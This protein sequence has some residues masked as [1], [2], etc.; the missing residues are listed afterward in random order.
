MTDSKEVT[1]HEASQWRNSGFRVE[2]RYFV[3]PEKA[4]VNAPTVQR[5]APGIDTHLVRQKGTG[6]VLRL[7][8]TGRKRTLSKS[9]KV[10]RLICVEIMGEVGPT[11]HR[12]E[13]ERLMYEHPNNPSLS[14]VTM[15]MK[16]G[17]LIKVGTLEKDTQPTI[18]NDQ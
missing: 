15:A 5:E 10:C 1:Q 18:G 14:A 11:I 6:A 17:R 16:V 9:E 13:L 3:Y 7:K 12:R 2:T 8:S 4:A